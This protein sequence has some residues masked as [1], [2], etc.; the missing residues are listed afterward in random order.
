MESKEAGKK[1]KAADKTHENKVEDQSDVGSCSP[2]T[3]EGLRVTKK[4]PLNSRTSALREVLGVED[5]TGGSDTTNSGS[6][7]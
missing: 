5:V 2:A 4:N 1:R 7:S 6:R 3:N